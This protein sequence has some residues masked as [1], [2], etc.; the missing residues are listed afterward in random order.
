MD[1][2]FGR[3]AAEI[4]AEG[5]EIAAVIESDTA[6]TARAI[7]R[8][9]LSA[10]AALEQLAPDA[11]VV[12]GDRFEALAVAIAASQSNVPLLHVEGGDKTEGGALDDSVRHAMTK[13]AHIHMATNPDAADQCAIDPDR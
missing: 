4:E 3:T 9:V 10:A 1:D 13:L 11:V 6:S 7:G 2:T 8:G 5:H 12:Y